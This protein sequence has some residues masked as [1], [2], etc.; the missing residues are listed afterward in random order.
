MFDRN[1]F[2]KLVIFI[3]SNKET[4]TKQ[5]LRI[6]PHIADIGYVNPRFF[7]TVWV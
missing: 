7:H 2:T 3:F 6:R 5:T 1:I 4:V